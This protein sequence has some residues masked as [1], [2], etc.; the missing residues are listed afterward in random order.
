M[1]RAN[2]R[3]LR[4]DSASAGA[5]LPDRVVVGLL[6]GLLDVVGTLATATG[7]VPPHPANPSAPT[8]ATTTAVQTDLRYVDVGVRVAKLFVGSRLSFICSAASMGSTRFAEHTV[9]NG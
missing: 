7:F 1:Q 5:G 6:A 8:A 4:C 2:F 9:G 3:G